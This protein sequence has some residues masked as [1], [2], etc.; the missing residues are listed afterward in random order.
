MCFDL[1]SHLVV[2]QIYLSYE[3]NLN[4]PSYAHCVFLSLPEVQEGPSSEF[5]FQYFSTKKYYENPIS[6]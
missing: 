3:L 1:F 5:Q 6:S 2:L 4:T